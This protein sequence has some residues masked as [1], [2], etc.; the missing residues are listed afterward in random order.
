MPSSTAWARLVAAKKSGA[1]MVEA[2]IVKF[3]GSL[4]S[5]RKVVKDEL[6]RAAVGVE[7]IRG[8]TRAPAWTYLLVQ[9]TTRLPH[10][11]RP[12]TQKQAVPA[13]R[14]PHRERPNARTGC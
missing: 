13:D 6:R 5:A 14:R 4:T 8:W 10:K 7:K 9:P 1:M 2:R 11:A 3:Q 12:E